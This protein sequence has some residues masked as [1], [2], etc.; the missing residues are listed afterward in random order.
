[1]NDMIFWASSVVI[2]LVVPAFSIIFYLRNKSPS[3]REL[4]RYMLLFSLITLACVIATIAL[5]KLEKPSEPQPKPA[6][7]ARYLPEANLD[8]QTLIGL[9][10]LLLTIPVALSGALVAIRIANSAEHISSRALMLEE[11]RYIREMIDV[12]R[13]R[14]TYFRE[15]IAQYREKVKEFDEFVS[16]HPSKKNDLV[17]VYVESGINGI[18][19]YKTKFSELL[20]L[21]NSNKLDTGRPRGVEKLEADQVNES[22]FNNVLFASNRQPALDDFLSA[23]LGDN[24][25]KANL[26]YAGKME[27]VMSDS[28]VREKIHAQRHYE[29]ALGVSNKGGEST[30]DREEAVVKY[31]LSYLNV[32]DLSDQPSRDLPILSNWT[33]VVADGFYV[34]IKTECV[35]FYKCLRNWDYI[36][37]EVQCVIRS[38]LVSLAKTHHD[39]NLFIQFAKHLDEPHQTEMLNN[40]LARDDLNMSATVIEALF[41]S[42]A[43]RAAIGHHLVRMSATDR[44]GQFFVQFAKHLDMPAQAEMLQ[45]VL[46]QERQNWAST[47]IKEIFSSFA[48]DA[49]SKVHQVLPGWFLEVVSSNDEHFSAAGEVAG[50]DLVM[51]LCGAGYFD[52]VRKEMLNLSRV[53]VPVV[54]NFAILPPGVYGFIKEQGSA[55]FGAAGA[56]R[57]CLETEDF[58]RLSDLERLEI[59]SAVIENERKVKEEEPF[60][61]YEMEEWNEKWNEATDQL[62]DV[63]LCLSNTRNA[64][65]EPIGLVN[66]V[67]L[68]ANILGQKLV[69]SSLDTELGNILRLVSGFIEDYK[70]D[71]NELTDDAM[72]CKFLL[73]WFFNCCDTQVL[74]S[75]AKII[76]ETLNL[77]PSSKLPRVS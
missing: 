40:I 61:G 47:D 65:S 48:P 10:S 71:G 45:N 14:L 17:K 64:A 46:S 31:A 37:E 57:K 30:E 50:F 38:Y 73:Y 76:S 15:D 70:L 63:L 52:A 35:D 36:C 19:P 3:L 77:G 55:L 69:L 42:F 23:A 56:I 25:S 62:K 34:L 51:R 59:L 68:V 24:K 4:W 21:A 1:M 18:A 26:W 72:K 32:E 60:F 74:G 20:A 75:L 9:I 7:V 41:A 2:A 67:S 53:N 12:I 5:I 16:Q 43:N 13:D 27:Y 66:I 22:L 29:E 54:G 39:I 44:D 11:V 6:D 58:A 28:A 33:S 49:L 8:G